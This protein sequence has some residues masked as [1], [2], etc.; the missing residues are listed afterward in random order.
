MQPDRLAGVGGLGG[1]REQ[2]QVTTF[3]S[4]AAARY[5]ECWCQG[6]WLRGHRAGHFFPAADWPQRQ[7]KTWERGKKVI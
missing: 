5:T 7:A 4:A 3:S 2:K 6:C 1:H